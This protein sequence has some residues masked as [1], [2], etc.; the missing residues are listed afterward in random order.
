VLVYQRT[1]GANYPKYWKNPGAFAGA[2]LEPQ[3]PALDKFLG[4]LS[5]V[6][7]AAFAYQGIEIVAV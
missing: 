5:V 7:Q 3:Y 4:I 2:G 6:A 1:G